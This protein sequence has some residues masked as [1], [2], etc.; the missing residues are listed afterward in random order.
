MQEKQQIEQQIKDNAKMEQERIRGVILT[1]L[2]QQKL[3]NANE[4]NLKS[5][6][7]N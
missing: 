3:E 4:K 2:E 5:L 1:H 7:A 6:V